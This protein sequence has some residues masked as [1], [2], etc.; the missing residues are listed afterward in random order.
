MFALMAALVLVHRD[1]LVTCN[2]VIEASQ[3]MWLIRSIFGFRIM[4]MKGFVSVHAS[5]CTWNMCR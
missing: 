1:K 4:R 3:P 2:V 5:S